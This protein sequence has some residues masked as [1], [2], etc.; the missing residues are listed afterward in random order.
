MHEL[1]GF[2]TA[3]MERVGRDRR[4]P[5]GASL[6]PQRS[7]T[8]T[9][10]DREQLGLVLGHRRDLGCLRQ[11]HL[12]GDER[13]SRGGTV[14]DRGHGAERG[15]SAA[16]ARRAGARASQS[17][18]IRES[19]VAMRRRTR[20]PSS[21]PARRRPGSCWP[22]G[23]AARSV[24]RSRHPSTGRARTPRG[25]HRGLR[26]AHGL[27]APDLLSAVNDHR[28]SRVRQ[29]KSTPPYPNA[30]SCQPPLREHREPAE[31]AGTGHYPRSAMV[32]IRDTLCAT[33]SSSPPG[34]PG[35]CRSTCAD[36]RCTT[37]RTS[38][39]GA[40]R[41]SF[42]AI[43]RYL[44]WTGVD[45][46]FVSNVTDVED[47]IIARAANAARTEPELAAQFEDVYFDHMDRLN[48]RDADHRPHATEY[49]DRCSP[50][51]AS[52]SSAA[53][54]TW[55]TGRACTS[56]SRRSPATARCRTARSRSCSSRRARGS[57]STRRSAARSTSRCGRRRSPASRVGI[58]VGTGSARLAH[59]VL[60]D[61]A[62]APRR[63]LRPPRRRRRPRVP[64]PRE[65]AGAGRGRRPPVRP[66]LD[67][68]RHGHV[69]GEKM[70]K[71]LGNFTT[72]RRR[73]RRRT[74]ARAFRLAC[75]RRTTAGRRSSATPSSMP[76]PGPSSASTRWSGARRERRRARRRAARRR[77]ARRVP[78]RDGRRLRHA[79][80]L[81]AIFDATRRANRAIDDGDVDARGVAGARRST[82]CSACS[83]STSRRRADAATTTPRSTRSCA[84][85]TMRAR[86]AT[87]PVPTRSATSS[88]RAASSSRTPRAAPSG[89]DEPGRRSGARTERV[90]SADPTTAASTNAAEK[91][92][93]R[94]RP[95]TAGRGTPRG[96]GA[97]RRRAA[98]GARARLLLDAARA[99][100]PTAEL[101][102]LAHTAGVRIKPVPAD[103]IERRARTDAPRAWSRSRRRFPPPTST[104]CS[105]IPRAFLVA[106][107]G[108]T[109]PAEPRRG[110]AQ[111]RDGRRDRHRV[112]DA[113]APRAH[114][115]GRQGRGRRDRVPARRLRVS[116]IPGALDRAKRAGV[117]C[118]GL[119]ADGDQSLFDLSVADA[120]LV[121]VLGAEGTRPLAPRTR[122][123]RRDRVDPDARSHRVAQRERGRRGRVHRDRSPPGGLTGRRR[124]GGPDGEPIIR[125]GRAQLPSRPSPAPEGLPR[126]AAQCCSP[127]G[128]SSPCSGARRSRRARP[129]RS[130]STSTGPP[131]SVSSITARS[132]TGVRRTRRRWR[133][134][135]TRCGC[136]TTA[137]S[138]GSC[139]PPATAM[140][141]AAFLPLGHAPRRVV[142]AFRVLA[143][144]VLTPG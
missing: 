57:T 22:C 128:C 118:V 19:T 10:R 78:G 135:A 18:G 119:D 38:A 102:E 54:P 74:T 72:R 109:D 2:S 143:A 138:A 94:P 117:W 69:G 114:A 58:A 122:A 64:A 80:A 121:L 5:S 76:R 31:A 40:P 30:R 87:S 33:P 8:R 140:L 131:A 125:C 28:G 136:R 95:R 42:D 110:H 142:R 48:V 123:L 67:A 113:T 60:G 144:L 6:L 26:R 56:R 99:T 36:R 37:S 63:G 44:E 53:T 59:R 41:W 50:S 77:D 108:V 71:S 100:R 23:T 82:S 91:A 116:G 133:R 130:T 98:Q 126:L 106:L 88:P 129:C 46:T 70:S 27:R 1:P 29:R 49:I 107:D 112:A 111:C 96:A 137:C 9:H 85:A 124:Q 12:P 127:S 43:R 101:E 66:P 92:R 68:H 89:T 21:P 79:P 65:R 20:R 16:R 81:A 15:A 141:H 103:Q 90:T 52:W 4:L 13:V 104:T 84:S 24:P 115:R 73:A 132:T 86:L 61:V 139:G 105:P 14:L 3:R 32:R 93:A 62:R 134:S 25:R 75:C 47:Q 45:V 120:P 7:Q 51:S 39:T 35:R 11:R 55:S 34:T 97:A 83:G 17:T